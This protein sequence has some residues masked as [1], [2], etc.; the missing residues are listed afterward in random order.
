MAFIPIGANHRAKVQKNAIQRLRE[1]GAVRRD[2]ARPLP[3]LPSLERRQ[4]NR[5]VDRGVIR[6]TP[7]GSYYLDRDALNDYAG[8]NRNLA[9]SIFVLVAGLIAGIV[10]TSA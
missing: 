3:D 8:R 2:Q 4:L 1:A 9:F 5:L 6:R 10:L 7:A